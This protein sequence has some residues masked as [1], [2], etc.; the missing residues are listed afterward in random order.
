M[1]SKK[2]RNHFVPRM[3]LKNFTDED[4]KLYF[5]DK[6]FEEKRILKTTPDALY[7]E[8]DLYVVRDED[9]KRDDSAE[10][11]FAEFERK[12]A[13]VFDKTITAVRDVKNPALSSSERE[14]LDRYIYFQWARVPDTAKPILDRTLKRLSLEDPEIGGLSPEELAEFGKGVN[15]ESLVGH[16][17]EPRERILSVLRNKSL[18]FVVIPRKSKS[19]VI[20]SRP[21]LQVFPDPSDSV[22]KAFTAMWLPLAHDVAVAYGKGEGG[23]M[24]FTE[25]R[26][27]RRFNENVFK[28]SRAIAGRSD[29]L[30]ASLA[31]VPIRKTAEHCLHRAEPLC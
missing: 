28:Q 2:R 26:E 29:K 9:G 10:E 20:G 31:G 3:L 4:G 11:R 13:P 23:L 7:R 12:V 14:M 22:P 27:L 19:F 18:A 24:E 1:D 25:D 16:I 30:I 15:V 5:F 8:R 17:T 6:R 21:V